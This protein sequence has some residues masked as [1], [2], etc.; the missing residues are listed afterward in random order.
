MHKMSQLGW[1]IDVSKYLSKF[2]EIAQLHKLNL[3]YSKI[4]GRRPTCS[5]SSNKIKLEQ[6]YSNLLFF[7]YSAKLVETNS[8]AAN[9]N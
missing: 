1:N 5:P 2:W 9:L 4:L 7:F 6:I 3:S 8:S